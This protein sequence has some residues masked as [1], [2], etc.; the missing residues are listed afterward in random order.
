VKTERDLATPETTGTTTFL[1]TDRDAVKMEPK[2]RA[3]L[4]ADLSLSS[5]VNFSQDLKTFLGKWVQ[6]DSGIIDSTSTGALGSWNLPEDLLSRPIFS[7]KLEGFQGLRGTILIKVLLNGTMYQQ[8]KLLV[9]F[10]PQS[11]VSGVVTAHRLVHNTT[12]TQL[13]HVEIDIACDSEAVI[14]IPY[15]SNTLF[16]NMFTGVGPW[17]SV[18]LRVYEP[19]ATGA[20]SIDLSYSVWACFDPKT[21][22]LFNPAKAA[23][24]TAAARK[25]FVPQMKSRK[26]ARRR[27]WENGP[28]PPGEK[29]IAG[30]MDG[31]ISGALQLA[32][33]VAGAASLIPA[34]SAVAAPASW[35]AGVG[36]K[37]A[38]AF[39]FSAPLDDTKA[40][41][42]TRTFARGWSNCDMPDRSQVLA[43]TAQN[44]VE[45]MPS[46]GPTTEDEL[47]ID[48]LVTRKAYHT[49]F[50]WAATDV[51][52]TVL[53]YLQLRPIEFQTQFGSG[54]STIYVRTPLCHVANQ[55]YLW[56]GD[57]VLTFKMVKTDMHYGRMLLVY[58]PGLT[59]PPA[60]P[61]DN[62][63]CHR[64]VIDITS[65]AEFE[66]SFPFMSERPYL[67]LLSPVGTAVLYVLNPL[68]F[69]DLVANSITIQVE[70][71]G[72]PGFEF[73]V[74][75]YGDDYYPAYV[76]SV[77]SVGR[78]GPPLPEVALKPLAKGSPMEAK[79][80]EK[81]LGP[82]AP[83]RVAS[84]LSADDLKRLSRP[85]Q[86]ELDLTDDDEEGLQPQSL[87][88]KKAPT[89][90]DNDACAIRTDSLG[91]AQEQAATLAPARLCVGER[92]TSIRQLIQRASGAGGTYTTNAM[93]RP[94]SVGLALYD[95]VSTVALRDLSRDA[96]SRWAVCYQYM[97]GSVRL[98]VPM[99]NGYAWAK[100][101]YPGAGAPIQTTSDGPLSGRPVILEQFTVG[102]GALELQVPQY[103]GLHARLIR[104]VRTAVNEPEDEYNSPNPGVL[105]GGTAPST[106]LTSSILRQ[107]GEDFQLGYWLGVP[108]LQL[109]TAT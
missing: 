56:R 86:I 28:R 54:A 48:F 65:G 95:G 102:S 57:I 80:E 35:V 81:R 104:P 52:M 64:A 103:L 41:M 67:E 84:P 74:P 97:R 38:S 5:V 18:Q 77:P 59:S 34:L 9:V 40:T 93:L 96:F 79:K 31:P 99:A 73:A 43:V 76:T 107:G 8:G 11:Q 61:T 24:F 21:V 45:L 98:K 1:N 36:A 109:V 42:M 88:S 71:S 13:P 63:F 7:D 53:G 90:A 68:K 26:T 16:Y 23:T 69:P 4:P 101:V 108:P 10:L 47:S 12:I 89:A 22:E 49:K 32:G 82:Y 72:A 60:D 94:W 55:F 20:G 27:G 70:A 91:G 30:E 85:R 58:Y 25:G 19:L 100:F 50:T 105:I 33:K 66:Y 2:P 37:L 14:E 62:V 39:G 6:L 78:T 106:I 87:V 15:I 92:I 83:R 17:G 51:S 46:L 75:Y 3:P 29:E 44:C